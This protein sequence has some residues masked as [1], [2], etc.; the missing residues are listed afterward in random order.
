MV[1]RVFRYTLATVL[2]GAVLGI[3]CGTA[4]AVIALSMATGTVTAVNRTAHTIDI[5]HKHCRI[6]ASG[7]ARTETSGS[8]QP[9]VIE[10]GMTVR[11]GV[12]SGQQHG[13]TI[14]LLQPVARADKR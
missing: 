12:V 3:C 7:P 8:T 11:Y 10:P 5:G 6:A 14:R 1:T 4:N 9:N 2:W 13:C